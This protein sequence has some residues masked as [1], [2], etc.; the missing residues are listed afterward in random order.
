MKSKNFW[1]LALFAVVITVT[2]F[3][4]HAL[5]SFLEKM[6]VDGKAYAW[7]LLFVWYFI[8]IYGAS[9]IFTKC[10]GVK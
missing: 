10:V 2:V 7:I 1:K 5:S 6:V 8:F 4:A 3:I 9:W